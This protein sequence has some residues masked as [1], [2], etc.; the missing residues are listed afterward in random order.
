M[1][2]N[3]DWGDKGQNGRGDVRSFT[4]TNATNSAMLAG[5]LDS[6]TNTAAPEALKQ[7]EA[8]CDEQMADFIS[9]GENGA[10]DR[11]GDIKRMVESLRS[12]TFGATSVQLAFIDQYMDDPQTCTLGYD[13]LRPVIK[14]GFPLPK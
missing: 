6:I 9:A 4:D 3:Q 7:F 2:K 10:D 8:L 13:V 14:A 5:D 12:W 1:L 11:R